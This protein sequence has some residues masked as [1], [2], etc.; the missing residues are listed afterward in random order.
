MTKLTTDIQRKLQK[1]EGL[2][3]MNRPQSLEIAEKTFNNRGPDEK[4][5]KRLSRILLVFQRRAK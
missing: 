5:N 3:G 1:L 4:K 2:E